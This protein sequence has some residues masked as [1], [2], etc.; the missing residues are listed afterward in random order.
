MADYIL[1]YATPEEDSAA[2]IPMGEEFGKFY[3]MTSVV[4]EHGGFRIRMRDLV[5]SLADGF[6]DALSKVLGMYGTAFLNG[7]HLAGIDY[8]EG[9][10]SKPFCEPHDFQAEA[11]LEARF[12]LSNNQ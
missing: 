4:R 10:G 6:E 9:N 11:F 1:R 5:G 8:G 3:E 12:V 2:Q 7:L